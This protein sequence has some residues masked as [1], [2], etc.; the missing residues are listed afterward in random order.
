M[1]R[2]DKLFQ[3]ANF[4]KTTGDY[5]G[6]FKHLLALNDELSAQM[7]E[8]KDPLKDEKKI[9]LELRD[10]CHTWVYGRGAKLWD[11]H[12]MLSKWEEHLRYVMKERG[13]D[14]PRKLDPGSSLLH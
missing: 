2:I 11:V 10:K 4:C 12:K 13:M 14:L 5:Q 9:S 7:K 3:L 1:M 8:D 6:W